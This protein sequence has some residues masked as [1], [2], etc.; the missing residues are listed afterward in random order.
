LIVTNIVLG[1]VVDT[2]TEAV[3]VTIRTSDTPVIFNNNNTRI[4]IKNS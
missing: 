3:S 2:I 4:N 1:A